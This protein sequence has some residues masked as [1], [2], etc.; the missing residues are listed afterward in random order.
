MK[1]YESISELSYNNIFEGFAC[2]LYWQRLRNNTGCQLLPANV[3]L[4]LASLGFSVNADVTYAILR[5]GGDTEV[6]VNDVGASLEKVIPA[7]KSEDT[8]QVDSYDGASALVRPP[9]EV[10]HLSGANSPDF[11][12]LGD[13]NV[14]GSVRVHEWSI[15]RHWANIGY[16][17]R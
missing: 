11:M 4:L 3:C 10:S 8:W 16:R 6:D 2:C 17:R 14:F 13:C 7:R 5:N 9:D 12:K 15:W 1:R